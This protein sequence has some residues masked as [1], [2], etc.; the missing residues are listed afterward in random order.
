[1]KLFKKQ[2]VQNSKLLHCLYEKA[3]EYFILE[4][5]STMNAVI[6]YLKI[7]IQHSWWKC[8]HEFGIGKYWQMKNISSQFIIIRW[9]FKKRNIEYWQRNYD[10]KI[11]QRSRPFDDKGHREDTKH[12]KIWHLVLFLC[13]TQLSWLLLHLYCF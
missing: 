11:I 5:T 4:V 6:W 9:R 2:D 1:M 7:G 8:I 12:N 10:I 13:H 3:W